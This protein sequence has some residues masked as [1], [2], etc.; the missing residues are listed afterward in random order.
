MNWR[1]KVEL[2]EEIRREY[3]LRVGTIRGIE[4]KLG[5]HRRMVRE[6]IVQAVPPRIGISDQERAAYLLPLSRDRP[7]A[8]ESSGSAAS[9]KPH[10]RATVSSPTAV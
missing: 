1:A 6:T 10:D 7:I 3:E 4:R 5:V 8:P 2:Y 9:M